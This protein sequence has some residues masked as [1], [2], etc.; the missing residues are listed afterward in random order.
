MVQLFLTVL[1]MKTL[2]KILFLSVLWFSCESSTEPQDENSLV[3]LWENSDNGGF[4]NLEL[5]PIQ[6]DSPAF[7]FFWND[8][9]CLDE[10]KGK[11]EYDDTLIY[12]TIMTEMEDCQFQSTQETREYIIDANLLTLINSNI[13]TIIFERQ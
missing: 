2:I 8:S 3:G 13:D 1:N 7:T 11:W 4:I 6:V 9:N 5:L 10:Q 12:F